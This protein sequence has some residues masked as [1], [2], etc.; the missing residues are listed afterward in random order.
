ML[1]LM[2]GVLVGLLGAIHTSAGLLAQSAS[3]NGGAA[4]GEISGPLFC[5]FLYTGLSLTEEIFTV[6]VE[7]RGKSL[8]PD[9]ELTPAMTHL[10][11][12]PQTI[13]S[14]YLI[15]EQWVAGGILH[16]DHPVI[17]AAHLTNQLFADNL[18]GAV[19]AEVSVTGGVFT[20]ASCN[21]RRNVWTGVGLPPSWF[22]DWTALITMQGEVTEGYHFLPVP[23]PASVFG[24]LLAAC[25]AYRRG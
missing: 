4:T 10:V 3:F 16:Y 25:L 17:I 19:A 11:N 24:M 18:T 7:A 21:F 1:K 8:R 5:S 23:E 13:N 9:Q 20:V 6:R 12:Y 22:N 15:E 14:Q 2:V